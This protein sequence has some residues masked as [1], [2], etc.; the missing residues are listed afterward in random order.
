[1]YNLRQRID[2]LNENLPQL[3]YTF[4]WRMPRLSVGFR[5]AEEHK[6]EVVIERFL[7]TCFI[8]GI[9]QG[10]FRIVDLMQLLVARRGRV[11]RSAEASVQGLTSS[12]TLVHKVLSTG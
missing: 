3:K 2:I 6:T 7:V 10:I 8:R 11:P 9:F 4:W 5:L 1:V 12:T